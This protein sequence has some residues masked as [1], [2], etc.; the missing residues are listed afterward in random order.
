MPQNARM[1]NSHSDFPLPS[2]KKTSA[3]PRLTVP[4][5]A[6]LQHRLERARDADGQPL[7]DELLFF[8]DDPPQG[9]CD[10]WQE[11]AD[12]C[13]AHGIKTSRMA[14]WRFYH[15]NILQWRSD[16]QPA[17][18][19][20]PPDP[21]ETAR[22]HAEARHLAA[23]RA[24]EILHDPGLSPGHII[25]LIQNDNLRQRVQLARDQFDDRIKVRHD[26]AIHQLRRSIENNISERH[27]AK[28]RMKFLQRYL[29]DKPAPPDKA[30]PG[31]P[32]HTA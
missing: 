18:P 23:R 3:R 21:A 9:T 25:G 7:R 17:P 26:Q 20:A 29:K 14:V 22:L 32:P 13:A 2:L 24:L 1:Q 16:Q 5:L 28:A 12:L 11:G 8:L 27:H 4:R 19:A 6:S 31:M 10:R 30:S 15:A